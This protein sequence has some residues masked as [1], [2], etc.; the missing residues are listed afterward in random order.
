MAFT[1]E[2]LKYRSEVL[3]YTGF[4]LCTPCGSIVIN[5]LSDRNYLHDNFSML[6]LLVS[7]IF[8]CLGYLCIERGLDILEKYGANL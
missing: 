6:Y 1:K 2:S 8:L 7:I 4:G 5:A 3:K